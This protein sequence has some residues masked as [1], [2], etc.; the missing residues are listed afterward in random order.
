MQQQLERE[1]SAYTTTNEIGPSHEQFAEE[2]TAKN[3]KQEEEASAYLVTK[4]TF[5]FPVGEESTD[6]KVAGAKV[7]E[8][9]AEWPNQSFILPRCF[10]ANQYKANPQCLAST[11]QLD[12]L[13]N[14][15]F[16]AKGPS[17]C[18]DNNESAKRGEET[19]RFLFNRLKE[20]AEKN[21]VKLFIIH[22]LNFQD[23]SYKLLDYIFHA[24]VYPRNQLE[25]DFIIFGSNGKIIIVECKAGKNSEKGIQQL[26][27]EKKFIILLLQMLN[28]PVKQ[29]NILTLLFEGGGQSEDHYSEAKKFFGKLVPH[30]TQETNQ[31]MDEFIKLLVFLKSFLFEKKEKFY[32]YTSAHSESD[33]ILCEHNFSKFHY[34]VRAKEHVFAKSNMNVYNLSCN[35]LDLFLHPLYKKE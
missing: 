24:S 17:D 27:R 21:R 14:P 13:K 26:D 9:F 22:K 5:K 18:G 11:S 34:L 6:W 4:C 23:P 25:I 28:I 7:W 10:V 2:P 20:F 35:Q 30:I 3:R 33:N 31:N 1:L 15:G 8:Q 32:S 12:Q 19:E 29:E 16:E